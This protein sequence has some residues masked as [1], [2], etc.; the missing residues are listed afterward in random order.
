MPRFPRAPVTKN[1]GT[2]LILA[3]PCNVLDILF[4]PCEVAHSCVPVAQIPDG[5]LLACRTGNAAADL[6]SASP[7]RLDAWIQ[8]GAGGT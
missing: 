4:A 3:V 2:G 6:C 5:I 8:L 7:T 1:E